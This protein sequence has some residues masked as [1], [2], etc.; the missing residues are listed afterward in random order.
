MATDVKLL[1]ILAILSTVL[2]VISTLFSTSANPIPPFIMTSSSCEIANDMP[3]VEADIFSY[4]S[5]LHLIHF[6]FLDV[7]LD[8]TCKHITSMLIFVP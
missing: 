8:L 7:V 1:L 6:P 3:N 2:L 5:A 4:S